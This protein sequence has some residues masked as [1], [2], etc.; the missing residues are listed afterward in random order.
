MNDAA[1][2]GPSENLAPGGSSG[3]RPHAPAIASVSA[4]PKVSAVPTVL[5]V[6]TGL[7]RTRAIA[8]VGLEGHVIDVEAHLAASIPGFTIVGLPDASLGEAKDRVR[9]AAT[10][11]GLTLP[12]RRITV[13][14]A[15]ASLPKYGASFDLAIAIAICAGAGLIKDSGISGIVHLGELGLDGRVHAVRGVLPMVAAAVRAGVERIVV[16][17]GNLAEA[18]LIEGI[19]VVGVRSLGG[20]VAVY[21]GKV[22]HA[23]LVLRGEGSAAQICDRQE[24]DLDMSD[25]L[26]QPE[27]RYALEVAAAGTHHL[28]MVGP[29]GAGKTMLAKR[30]PGI[31]PDLSRGHAIEVTSIHSL[32]GRFSPDHGLIHRPP[33]ED[34]HH[35]ATA[36]SI[37]GGG[38]GT[39]RPGAVSLAHR[40]VLFLDEAPEYSTR[41]LQTLRQPIEHGELM[42]TRAAGTARYPAR[43][44]LVLAA[45][46]CPCGNGVGPA[47]RDCSCTSLAKRRYFGRLSGPLLDRID[48]H[49]EVQAVQRKDLAGGLAESS[50]RIARRVAEARSAAQERLAG[51]G[52]NT[53]AEAPGSWVRAQLGAH[54]GLLTEIDQGLE[55]GRLTMRSADRVLKVA[56]TIAD[57]EGKLTPTRD[58][59]SRAISLRSAGPV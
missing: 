9:A 37:V 4:M 56:W 58:S 55:R 22:P 44:Q 51:T 39:P 5:P 42:L 43:F 46:P 45:N 40:G 13:N 26:G 16:P 21:G 24:T 29:P 49:C 31:L 18:S 12:Q 1:L 35:T 28:L 8:L 3:E 59:I 23:P 10:N 38:S 14:L 36:A 41:V 11:S 33:F 25:V 54:R 34:P 7:G 53:S 47:S 15:P 50:L 2:K 20:L 57:L 27:A 48:V 6:G 30:L 32:A 17:E 52:W 19:D